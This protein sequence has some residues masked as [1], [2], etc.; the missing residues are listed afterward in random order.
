MTSDPQPP[1]DPA[2]SGRISAD[3]GRSSASGRPEDD[4][5]PRG[6]GIVVRDLEQVEQIACPECGAPAGVR[7]T[8]KTWLPHLARVKAHADRDRDPSAPVRTDDAEAHD[9]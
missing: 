8:W 7:C 4:P 9:S 6:A 3:P 5:P 2:D 1:A